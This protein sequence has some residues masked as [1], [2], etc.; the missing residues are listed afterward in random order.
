MLKELHVLS[1]EIRAE[2]VPT[3]D[4]RGISI[5]EVDAYAVEALRRQCVW[6]AVRLAIS[7]MSRLSPD[8]MPGEMHRGELHHEETRPGKMLHLVD[9]IDSLDRLLRSATTQTATPYR[10]DKV[11]GVL[12]GHARI[13]E[14][15]DNPDGARVSL[16]AEGLASM[17]NTITSAVSPPSDGSALD[18]LMGIDGSL[19]AILKEL[20]V[21]ATTALLKEGT[22]LSQ[23]CPVESL[24]VEA[25][26]EAVTDAQ[27]L[28]NDAIELVRLRQR[29][30][31]LVEGGGAKGV[32][33]S[34]RDL[35]VD[36]ALVKGLRETFGEQAQETGLVIAALTLAERQA[37]ESPSAHRLR[38][39]LEAQIAYLERQNPP[40]TS[41]ELRGP[42]TREIDLHITQ[43]RLRLKSVQ[44]E[45]AHCREELRRA[46]EAT[47]RLLTLGGEQPAKAYQP[48][49][50]S[51]TSS[52]DWTVAERLEAATR[53]ESYWRARVEALD[54]SGA[55]ERDAARD[56]R[57][58]DVDRYAQIAR[59]GGLTGTELSLLG[60]SEVGA[61]EALKAAA[62]FVQR[63]LT[64][65]AQVEAILRD[66]NRAIARLSGGTLFNGGLT[67]MLPEHRVSLGGAAERMRLSRFESLLLDGLAR[68]QPPSP[69]RNARVKAALEGTEESPG[70]MRALRKDP[71][72]AE[73][74]LS[75][76]GQRYGSLESH[77]FSLTNFL[78]GC[79]RDHAEAQR[80]IQQLDP[81]RDRER[82]QGLAV[83]SRLLE[84]VKLLRWNGNTAR[85]APEDEERFKE[86]CQSLRGLDE[87]TLKQPRLASLRRM[88]VPTFTDIARMAQ[89][90][91]LMKAARGIVFLRQQEAI[92]RARL[93]RSVQDTVDGMDSLIDQRVAAMGESWE[94]LRKAVRAAIL[95]QLGATPGARIDTFQPAEH[96]ESIR[97]LLSSWGVPVD[98]VLPEIHMILSQSFGREELNRWVQTTGE[99]VGAA[100]AEGTGA[101]A[102]EDAVKERN[103]TRAALLA[104][105][106]V[107]ASGTKLKLGASRRVDV[108]TGNIPLEPSGTLNINL[109]VGA[110][111]LSGLEIER[112][113]DAY[114]LVLREGWEGRASGE[115]NAAVLAANM[116]GVKLQASAGLEGTGYGLTGLV[117]RFPNSAGGKTALKGLV[118]T[119]IDHG[120]LEPRDLSTACEILPLVERRTGGRVWGGAK[121]GFDPLHAPDFVSDTSEYGVAGPIR[122]SPRGR[123][124]AYAGASIVWDTHDANNTNLR[125]RK[126]DT[127]RVIELSCA[128]GAD[129]G[130]QDIAT[131]PAP[132]KVSS[133][134]A[135][136]QI[137]MIPYHLK[138]KEREIRGADGLV[139]SA[140]LTRQSFAPPELVREAA[141]FDHLG[142]PAFRRLFASLTSAQQDE[143]RRILAIA[144]GRD[145]IS[146]VFALD[147]SVRTAV[148]ELLQRANA[149]RTGRIA[150][151]TRD[152]AIENAAELEAS[153]QALL[154]DERSYIPAKLQLIPT[155]ETAKALPGIN[156]VFAVSTAYDDGKSEWVA[157]EMRFDAAEAR[158]GADGR[159]Q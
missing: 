87:T 79:D 32:L 146:I 83:S 55:S 80:A 6:N 16:A 123:V 115:F 139:V 2:L 69:N 126:R 82:P 5:D 61:D 33:T 11:I 31:Q 140:E 45:I 89:N 3:D 14:Y 18:A 1:G 25:C 66:A 109:K 64:S 41:Q 154:A 136:L 19:D 67:R 36:T 60:L 128:L 118:A 72:P 54:G 97:D 59:H 158:R 103:E 50:P 8:E 98:R 23:G 38:E 147:E 15:A 151:D 37:R 94:P 77:L 113:S 30:S 73:D 9:S 122:A 34:F 46:G 40:P 70:P 114:L 99:G 138:L 129:V 135:S 157:A 71:Q 21:G 153:V 39:A 43:L 4:I 20:R 150:A 108:Q 62:E 92:K 119:L 84:A 28:V 29:V 57:Q 117:L 17:A 130:M 106:D 7:G 78:G 116:V 90:Q 148:N 74:I 93:L 156:L 141:V 159:S 152:A 105:I 110:G 85:I 42:A 51:G 95:V 63:G 101:M 143:I 134:L 132:Y 65:A 27:T 49:E 12:A 91:P 81:S 47:Q 96:E 127:T 145:M 26:R 53:N 125:I 142:G 107:M 10:L 120:R 131:S 75:G 44:K 76:L 35:E 24:G 68:G 48:A 86:L 100:L 58:P 112:G 144:G 102:P 22:A 133:D 137:A 13:L 121:L 88:P 149:L 104:G 56:A 155:V 52:G 124:K 111:K